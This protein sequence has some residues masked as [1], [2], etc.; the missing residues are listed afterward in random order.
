MVMHINIIIIIIAA[1]LNRDVWVFAVVS[2][3]YINALLY[4]FHS[5]TQHLP[6]SWSLKRKI[7]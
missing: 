4:L 5:T 1:K 7:P 3:S 2:H 6:G